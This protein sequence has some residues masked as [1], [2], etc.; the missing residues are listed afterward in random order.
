MLREERISGGDLWRSVRNDI[1]FARDGYLLF[2]ET[3]V[4]KPYGKKIESVRRQWSGS[5]KRVIEGIG[6]VPCLYVNPKKTVET[7]TQ[8]HH[9]HGQHSNHAH[10]DV[11]PHS[12]AVPTPLNDNEYD[13]R[14][15][16][17]AKDETANADPWKQS[18]PETKLTDAVDDTYPPRNWFET[19]DPVLF[20][21]Y[22]RAQLIKQFGERKEVHILA[23]I[24]LK[25]RQRLPLTRDEYI[26]SLKARYALFPDE[27]TLKT[28][29]HHLQQKD[30]RARIIFGGSTSER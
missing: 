5:E 28:L 1:D 14:D 9:D 3:V 18:Y 15:D 19:K 17:A 29:E 16:T 30:T 24:E 13:W 8:H 20:T 25:K 6:I 27:R 11:A 22:F 7:D 26:S 21:K 23:D 4:S 12:H 2:D 10:T